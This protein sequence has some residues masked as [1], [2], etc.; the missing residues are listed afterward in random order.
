MTYRS[1]HQVR[2]QLYVVSLDPGTEG[3]VVDP[4]K[5]VQGA[6]SATERNGA[7]LSAKKAASDFSETASDLQYVG[8]TGFEPAT[9]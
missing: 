8:L 9:T 1:D 4:K 5:N 6:K 7:P 2:Y 3:T